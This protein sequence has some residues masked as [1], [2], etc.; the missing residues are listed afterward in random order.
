MFL[1]SRLKTSQLF[2]TKALEAFRTSYGLVP[3][4]SSINEEEYRRAVK[5]SDAFVKRCCTRI[6][7]ITLSSNDPLRHWLVELCLHEV[8]PKQS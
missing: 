6:V 5:V 7:G 4:K 1:S 2:K 8:E 3:E